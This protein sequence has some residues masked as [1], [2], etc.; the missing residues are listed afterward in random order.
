MLVAAE[1]QDTVTAEMGTVGQLM[2]LGESART[3][4]LQ[5]PWLPLR[6]RQLT[7]ALAL[8]DAKGATSGLVAS[9]VMVA[10]LMLRLKSL[11]ARRVD[12]VGSLPCNVGGRGATGRPAAAKNAAT[13]SRIIPIGV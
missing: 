5:L 8:P 7:E 2:K 1:M 9:K 13:D 10:G 12:M 3:V 4:K 11:A 6:E